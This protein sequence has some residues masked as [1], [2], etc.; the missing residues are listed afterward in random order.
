M[1]QLLQ[2]SVKARLMALVCLSLATLAIAFMLLNVY[3]LDKQIKQGF[4]G[5][6]ETASA[7]F[8]RQLDAMFG[9]Y[10]EALDKAETIFS[11]TNDPESYFN[12]VAKT[13]PFSDFYIGL[14]DGQFF[15][16]DNEGLPKDYDPRSR[17]WYKQ[18]KS[19]RPNTIFTEAYED[20]G[21]GE[22]VFSVAKYFDYQAPNGVTYQGVVA[23][24]VPFSKMVQ[25]IMKVKIPGAVP[26]VLKKSGEILAF[27]DASYVT[28]PSS[29]LSDDLAINK[30]VKI[31]EDQ[32]ASEISVNNQTRLAYATYVL[33]GQWIFLITAD[34][35][36]VYAPLTIALLE[37]GLMTA[38]FIG[39]ALI[40]AVFIFGYTLRP[41]HDLKDAMDR[42]QQA[43]A[44]GEGDL[45]QQ[46]P[47]KRPDEFGALAKLFNAF[48]ENIR[49]I[50][51]DNKAMAEQVDAKTH[52]TSDLTS[53]TREKLSIQQKEIHSMTGA[54]E[55][56]LE[57]ANSV[58]THAEEAAEL[59]VTSTGHCTTGKDVILKNQSSISQLAD[60]VENSAVIIQK[61]NENSQAI[62]AIVTTIQ[63]I[64]D[65][66]N[67][68]ALNAAIEAARAGDQG[69]GFAVVADEVRVLAQRT[70]SSTDEIRHMIEE[71]QV[72]T[73]Q[74]VSTMESSKNL[75]QS[76]VEETHEA[77]DALESITG[78]VEAIQEVAKNITQTVDQQVTIN[79]TLSSNSELMQQVGDELSSVADETNETA[80]DVSNLSEQLRQKVA[81]I[82]L[83]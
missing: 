37:A 42:A 27:E 13:S 18:A 7:G 77:T 68:L 8:N 20:A 31:V 36:E 75:A 43:V 52:S 38:I 41:V 67:L 70:R 5:Q 50:M 14:N 49:L 64:A 26:V 4:L 17:D 56:I 25:E 44:K 40:A 21:T 12:Y 2:S 69:R 60:E 39:G 35:S 54:I 22:M 29:Q 66:T 62:Q 58:Q 10:K 80:R 47:I 63:D 34:K 46:L 78:S 48:Q 1:F 53:K 32:G 57:T 16:R 73:D 71:L 55:E 15:S 81:G 61:L 72:N 24:D 76:S 19:S 30:L 28:Q 79:K 33:D 83:E 82:K 23:A 9:S 3:V 11:V 6:A 59:A 65:Q 51:L 74:A 45:T